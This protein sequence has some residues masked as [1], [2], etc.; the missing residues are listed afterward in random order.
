MVIRG[1]WWLKDLKLGRR[2]EKRAVLAPRGLL[3]TSRRS[4]RPAGMPLS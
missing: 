1:L 4:D 3:M 2:R